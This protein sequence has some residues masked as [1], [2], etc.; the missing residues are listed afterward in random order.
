MPTVG[1]DVLIVLLTALLAGAG[2]ALVQHLVPLELRKT[3]TVA[4]GVIYR[5]TLRH[6]WRISWFFVLSRAGRVP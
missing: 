5:G 4:I 6:V 1:W 2:A 3:H